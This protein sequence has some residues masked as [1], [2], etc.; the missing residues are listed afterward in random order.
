MASGLIWHGPS[1]KFKIKEGMQRN[2]M[3]AAIFVVG[4]VKQSLATAGPTKTNPHTPA[5][6]PGEPPHRRTGTLS[7]SI[8]HE[9]TAATARVGTNIKYGKFLETGTSKMAA[10]PYLR[11]GVYKNQREIKKILGRKIT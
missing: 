4:K 6:G 3:A 2:L 11:P 10:R 1:V 5:S 7:R 9:V 8:T